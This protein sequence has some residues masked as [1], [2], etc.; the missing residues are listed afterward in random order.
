M[1]HRR[2]LASLLATAL[3]AP[4]LAHPPPRTQRREIVRLQ[5]HRDAAGTVSDGRM[6]LVVLGTEHAFAA[7]ARQVF[8]LTDEEPAPPPADRYTLQGPRD[9]LA[10]LAAARPEQTVT[11]LGEHRPG[12]SDLFVLTLDLCPPR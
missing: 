12:S 1:R 3:A 4:A 10:H 7:S 8:A 5:G 9:L 2:L 11:I 6:T